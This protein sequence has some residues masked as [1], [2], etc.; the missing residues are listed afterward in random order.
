M[1][2]VRSIV[3][4]I[5]VSAAAPLA[6]RALC[7]LGDALLEVTTSE[8]APARLRPVPS[9]ADADRLARTPAA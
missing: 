3:L 6:R 2:R 1:N 7:G 8:R 4:L 5:A 9:A